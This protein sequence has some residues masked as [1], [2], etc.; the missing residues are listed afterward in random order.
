MNRSPSRNKAIAR[1]TSPRE[2]HSSPNDR[3]RSVISS[4]VWNDW[5]LLGIFLEKGEFGLDIDYHPS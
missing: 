4:R 2:R 3:N 1:V 5:D